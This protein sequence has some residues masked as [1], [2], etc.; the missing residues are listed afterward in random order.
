[1]RCHFLPQAESLRHGDIGQLFL[2][3]CYDDLPPDSLRI[4]DDGRQLY[5]DLY[6]GAFGDHIRVLVDES[7]D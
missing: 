4:S 7:N 2:E 1:L 5:T 3:G 6:V